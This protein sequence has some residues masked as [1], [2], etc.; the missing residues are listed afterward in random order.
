MMIYM[1]A[2]SVQVGEGVLAPLLMILALNV[3]SLRTFLFIYIRYYAMC[4]KIC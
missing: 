2:V 4:I 3:E 1:V